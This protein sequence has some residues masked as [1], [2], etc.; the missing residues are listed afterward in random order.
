MAHLLARQGK[1]FIHHKLIKSCLIVTA[2]RMC[3]KKINSGLLSFWQ[4]QLLEK[5]MTLGKT[6][7]IN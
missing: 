6:S 1:H 7:M 3:P 5:L 4:E 2:G